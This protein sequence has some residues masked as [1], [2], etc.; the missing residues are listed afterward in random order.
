VKVVAVLG[1]LNSGKG[2]FAK[3]FED[4]GFKPMAFADP[5]KCILQELFNLPTEELW[6]PSDKRSH[7]SR[8][9]MQV[10]GTDFARKYD[11]DIWVKRMDKRIQ[12][13]LQ[14]NIDNCFQH[15]FNKG[16][17]HDKIVITDLRFPNEAKMLREKYD[18]IL[19]KVIRPHSQE[20]AA[21]EHAQHISETAVGEIPRELIN[22]TVFN[23]GTL[24]DLLDEAARLLETVCS[25]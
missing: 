7:R 4:A 11:P 13:Y 16:G 25:Q 3:V 12:Q 8:E 22:Y 17:K 6:G 10:F 5:I 19:I 9:L 24:E 14:E 18:A 1:T 20:I 21:L 2:T 15:L 23:T